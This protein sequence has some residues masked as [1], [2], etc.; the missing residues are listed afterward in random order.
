MT[1]AQRAKKA[2]DDTFAEFKDFNT[3]EG[4]MSDFVRE[5]IKIMEDLNKHPVPRDII[6]NPRSTETFSDFV[7]TMKSFAQNQ[8][9]IQLPKKFF[10]FCDKL[11]ENFKLNGLR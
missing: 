4:D 6:S 10:E 8:H 5:V 2:F 1:T 7:D 9:F 3:P 11:K